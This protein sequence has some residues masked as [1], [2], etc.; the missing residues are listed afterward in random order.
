MINETPDTTQYE[1]FH[2]EKRV[3]GVP[4]QNNNPYGGGNRRRNRGGQNLNGLDQYMDDD[5]NLNEVVR[6]HR[7]QPQVQ[8]PVLTPPPVQNVNDVDVVSVAMFENMNSNALLTLAN[9]KMSQINV[10]NVTNNVDDRQVK[11][12]NS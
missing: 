11:F 6:Q 9:G 3:N 8:T 10:N 2:I 12:L 7:P 4:Q 5:D 1:N